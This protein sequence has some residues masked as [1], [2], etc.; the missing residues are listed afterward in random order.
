MAILNTSKVKFR[1]A[2]FP[3]AGTYS[4][5]HKIEMD[6]NEVA[7]LFRDYA[8]PEAA[9]KIMRQVRPQVAPEYDAKNPL[10]KAQWEAAGRPNLKKLDAH[11]DPWRP[12]V[13]DERWDGE[14]CKEKPL[15][16]R[17][18]VLSE[19]L[20]TQFLST[21]CASYDE[22]IALAYRLATASGEFID[23]EEI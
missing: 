19:E 8:S 11:G 1:G 3:N 5:L 16:E 18:I 4:R 15:Q 12:T 14:T 2:E 13:F 20:A 21:P 17:R 23:A 22:A 7:I 10:H 9:E 6:K